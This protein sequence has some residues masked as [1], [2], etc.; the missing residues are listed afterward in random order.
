MLLQWGY[1]SLRTSASTPAISA[2]SSSTRPRAFC[3]EGWERRLRL[4]PVTSAE[5]ELRRL[6]LRGL[7]ASVDAEPVEDLGARSAGASGAS[8]GAGFAGGGGFVGEGVG[9]PHLS[10]VWSEPLLGRCSLRRSGTG[11]GTEAGLCAL[12]SL[13]TGV[14]VAATLAGL[15]GSQSLKLDKE[16]L[17]LRCRWRSSS[18]FFRAASFAAA[19]RAA[20]SRC[21]LEN[22]R[23]L[24]TGL[25]VDGGGGELAGL[26]ASPFSAFS[27]SFSFSF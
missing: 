13:N 19:S 2:S 26:A 5:S 8:A 27:F 10:V 25:G 18:A 17:R 20:A 1:Y 21:A 15:D 23:S 22:R 9:F 14:G 16:L 11:D 4:R 6:V 12:G 7:L 3:L 24:M